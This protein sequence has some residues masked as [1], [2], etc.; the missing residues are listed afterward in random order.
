MTQVAQGKN[1]RTR[2][3]AAATAA[4]N[5]AKKALKNAKIEH[6]AQNMQKVFEAY[7]DDEH[8]E[9]HDVLMA[10]TQEELRNSC[11]KLY[12]KECRSRV[13]PSKNTLDGI[14]SKEVKYLPQ[15]KAVFDKEPVD[16]CPQAGGRRGKSRKSKGSK[17]SR[18]AKRSTRRR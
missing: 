10:N 4:A 1:E 5:K 9:V 14:V 16:H 17:K 3:A 2:T 13:N 18:K 8:D 7:D 11:R 6:G 15:C 12:F